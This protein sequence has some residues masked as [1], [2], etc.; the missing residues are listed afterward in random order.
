MP[1]FFNICL[2]GGLLFFIASCAGKVIQHEKLRFIPSDQKTIYISSVIN[3]GKE[4]ELHRVIESQ[5]IQYFQQNRELVYEGRLNKADVY[6][7]MEIKDYYI[8]KVKRTSSEHRVRLWIEVA[9]TLKNIRTK[10][11]F[12]DNLTYG[13]SI[14]ENIYINDGGYSLRQAKETLAKKLAE[15]VASVIVKGH[16]SIRTQFGYEDLT[17]DRALSEKMTDHYQY[18]KEIYE[19]PDAYQQKINEISNRESRIKSLDKDGR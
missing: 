10:K 1:R 7:G 18:K 16:P 14:V 8:H 6:L 4:R 5:L 19:D 9:V 3:F 13:L 17:D 12:V 15:S 11:V 2:K